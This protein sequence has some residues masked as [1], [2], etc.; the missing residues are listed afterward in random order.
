MLISVPAERSTDLINALEKH[1]T[2]GV[3]VGEIVEGARIRVIP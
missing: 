3:V 1:G 2:S